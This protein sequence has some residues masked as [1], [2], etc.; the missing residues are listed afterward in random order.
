VIIYPETLEII[1]TDMV[2]RIFYIVFITLLAL[3]LSGATSF[4]YSSDCGMKCCQ[5]SG[6]AGTVSFIAPTCCD[7]DG[8]TCGF[9]TDRFEEL[10]DAVLA[11]I[12]STNSTNQ[13]SNNPFTVANL[14]TPA[15]SCTYSITPN[16]TESPP[17]TPVY[18]SNSAIRS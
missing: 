11:R 14:Y 2:K 10:F 16:P 7:M 13:L 3:N 12:N 6:W 4:A 17:S 1:K 9:E 5:P 8:V 18:L 15:H